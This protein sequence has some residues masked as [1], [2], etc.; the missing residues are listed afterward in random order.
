MKKPVISSIQGY[1]LGGAFELAMA[2]D[3]AY[4]DTS[5]QLGEPEVLL[6]DAPPFLI[7]PWVMGMRQA[8]HILLSGEL[9]VVPKHV[10]HGLL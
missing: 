4:A 7:S 5:A 8:K 6:S 10:V 2:C 9:V 3:F 1:C